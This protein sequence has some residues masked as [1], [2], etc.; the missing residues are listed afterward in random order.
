MS[1]WHRLR[2]RETGDEQ[3]VLDLRGYN[4]DE[5]EVVELDRAPEED[6]DFDW[7]AKKLVKN[8]GKREKREKALRYA[9]MSH[10]RL[11]EVVEALEDRVRALEALTVQPASLDGGKQK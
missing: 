2:H 9:S 3:N 6:D 5:F 7:Q 11:C 10:Q 4:L 1:E 8:Q